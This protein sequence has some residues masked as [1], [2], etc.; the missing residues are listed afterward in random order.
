MA[1]TTSPAIGTIPSWEIPNGIVSSKREL[2]DKNNKVWAWSI[3][4]MGMGGQFDLL[5][6]DEKTYNDL[7][8]GQVVTAVGQ[9]DMSGGQLR[10]IVKHVKT[11]A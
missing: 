3:K 9:F 6:K 10:L 5:T 8:E 7:V 4:M 2:T 11:A 1:T